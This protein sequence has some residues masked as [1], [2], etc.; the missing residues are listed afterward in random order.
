MLGRRLF[1]L[2]CLIICVGLI[3]AALPTVV[4]TRA[5]PPEV[6]AGLAIWRANNCEG[7]HTLYGQG[8]AY[9][10]DL[11]HIYRQRGEGYLREFLINPQA[12]HPGQRQMPALGL[13]DTEM[14]NL[15]TFLAWVGAQEPGLSWP[16]RPIQVRGSSISSDTTQASTVTTSDDPVVRGKALFS[17]P[18]AICSTCHSVV[19]DVVIVGPS[20]AGIA[21]TAASRVGDQNAEQYIRNSILNPSEYVVEG[22][23]DVMQKNFSSVLTAEQIN[24]LIAYLVTLK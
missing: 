8:S 13:T 9:A 4:Q 2:C 6:E 15:L 7:C 11:T 24:D 1:F 19:P 3:A 20:L 22:F 14:K 16:P 23:Q 17:S 21:T 5:V 18:P 10:P 12:F